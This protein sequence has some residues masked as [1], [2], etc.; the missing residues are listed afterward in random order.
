ME[1]E[2][3]YVVT[4]LDHILYICKEFT[5]SNAQLCVV[6]EYMQAEWC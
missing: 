6:N 3:D 1:S 5:I 4:I 2:W